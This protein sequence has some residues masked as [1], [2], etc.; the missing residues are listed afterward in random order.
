MIKKLEKHINNFIF[1]NLILHNKK[2]NG[3]I[4]KDEMKNYENV[5][6]YLEIGH[7]PSFKECKIP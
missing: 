2:K 5:S 3:E 7:F 6:N 4:W 1:D